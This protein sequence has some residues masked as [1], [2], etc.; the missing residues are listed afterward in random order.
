MK[1]QLSAII[2]AIA[3]GTSLSASAVPVTLFDTDINAGATTFDTTVTGVGGTVNTVTLGGLSSATSWD[4]GDFTIT[5]NDGGTSS[6]FAATTDNSSGQMI[7]IGPSGT[8]ADPLNYKPSGITFTFDTAINALGFEVGDWATCCSPSNLYIQF[9]GGALQTVGQATSTGA[10]GT[11]QEGSLGSRQSVF[12]SAIDDTDTFTSVSFWGD[13]VG[14]VLTAGGRIRYGEVA[15]NSIPSVSEPSI[16]ALLGLGL[17]L[18]G[19]A[20]RKA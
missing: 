9:D 10:G 18:I 6:I 8:G 15:L 11:I 3:L 13:G 1:T 4:L 20:R 17:G 7:S 16:V 12:V 2:G 19:F 5:N 14:E